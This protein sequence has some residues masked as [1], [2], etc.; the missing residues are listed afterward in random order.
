MTIGHENMS[1]MIAGVAGS[2]SSAPYPHL[3]EQCLACLFLQLLH[4]SLVRSLPLLPPLLCILSLHRLTPQPACLRLILPILLY[5]PPTCC[6]TAASSAVPLTEHP[7]PK[8]R[9]IKSVDRATASH[10][11]SLTLVAVMWQPLW[12]GGAWLASGCLGRPFALAASCPVNGTLAADTAARACS[13]N[14]APSRSPK[15][16]TSGSTFSRRPDRSGPAWQRQL[17]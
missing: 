13:S 17:Y 4:P 12:E 2:F 14:E 6:R 8:T 11:H 9:A 15:P 1:F 7:I 10:A 3:V 5:R 16:A